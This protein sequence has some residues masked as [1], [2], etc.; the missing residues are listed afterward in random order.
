MTEGIPPSPN[1]LS[2]SSQGETTTT[3]LIHNGIDRKL[4]GNEEIEAALKKNIDHMIQLYP[5]K[6]CLQ[7]TRTKLTGQ[8]CFI[9]KYLEK[10]FNDDYHTHG[11]LL[12]NE[13]TNYGTIRVSSKKSLM[14]TSIAMTKEA[15]KLM[16]EDY[17]MEVDVEGISQKVTL[18]TTRIKIDDSVIEGV[19]KQNDKLKNIQSEC[20]ILE[21]LHTGE[22]DKIIKQ[23]ASLK[24]FMSLL[25][26]A[27]L[28]YNATYNK[29]KE[30]FVE[31]STNGTFPRFY[32]YRGVILTWKGL[33]SSEGYYD[34]IVRHLQEKDI[35]DESCLYED[36]KSEMIKLNKKQNKY[37][38][39][40]AD[41]DCYDYEK[42]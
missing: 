14:C 23:C 30:I 16:E 18:D 35:E 7:T 24:Q 12:I 11:K 8:S 38:I 22:H 21:N 28:E 34:K 17:D 1:C 40:I 33:K 20:E 41:L 15:L 19:E 29:L 6:Q 4:K 31:A 27:S 2:P 36:F 13:K 42:M 9:R 5:S 10:E 25:Y 37:T 39:E 32:E 3:H 26:P